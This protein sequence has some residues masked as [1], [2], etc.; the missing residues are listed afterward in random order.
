MTTGIWVNIGSGNG[1][2][3]HST[4][5]LPKPMLTYHK[6]LVTF[7]WEPISE[8]ILQQSMTQLVKKLL[9]KNIVQI[10]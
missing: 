1:L 6:G 8:E 10:S 2:L 4:K 5:P 3:P 7:I 9:I